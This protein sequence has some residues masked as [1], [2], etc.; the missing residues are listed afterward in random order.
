M[1]LENIENPISQRTV[2]TDDFRRPQFHF[3]P[4]K[5]G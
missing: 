1:T 4:Q 2:L 5:T 3:L